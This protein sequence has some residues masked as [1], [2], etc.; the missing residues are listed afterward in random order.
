M[1]ALARE[2]AVDPERDMAEV[3]R[4]FSRVVAGPGRQDCWLW[5]GAIGDDGYGR[6]AI[7]RDGRLRMVRPPRYALAVAAGGAAL[8]GYV[9][10]LHECDVPMCVRV[11]TAVELRGGVRPHV[12]GGTQRENMERMAR[13]RRG[14]GS[15]A[16]IARQAGVKAR[17]EQ[18]L[19]LRAAVRSGWDGAAVEAALLGGQPR[20]W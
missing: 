19:A 14:G 16:V 10:A 2:L 6:F 15:P 4:F 12:V 7:R 3:A 1:G 5:T 13:A 8:D 17:R 9:R 20:L 18:A 11:I